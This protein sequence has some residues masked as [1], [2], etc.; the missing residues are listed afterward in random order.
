M[1]VTPTNRSQSRITS[2][3]ASGGGELLFGRITY[4]MMASFWPTPQAHA[5]AP[6]VAER[7]NGLPKVVFSKTLAQA[8]WN[9]TRLLKGELT[10]EVRK[11][12]A[13]PGPGMVL[14][15]S[16]SVISQLA[17]ARL[18]DQYQFAI[19]P[20]VLGRGRT[21]FESL[22]TKLGLKFVQSRNFKNGNVVVWYQ[23]AT[24]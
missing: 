24:E 2:E 13:E 10:A 23:A 3:N 21:L 9:N 22:E 16:G 17:Q 7:M 15:G 1:L 19:N 11:L 5:S 18:I 14:M 20:I 6:I 4:E 12:K 8:T